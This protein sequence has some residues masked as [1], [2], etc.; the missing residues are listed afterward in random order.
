V[1]CFY[2]GRVL[3]VDLATGSVVRR[4]DAGANPTSIEPGPDGT[5]FFVLCGGES[6]LLEVRL[7]DGAIVARLPLLFGAY[8]MLPFRL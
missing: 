3:E 6:A 5:S 1:S 8:A 7:S 4:I 2:T